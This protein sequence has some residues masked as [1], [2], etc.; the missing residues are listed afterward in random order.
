[1]ATR[2][3]TGRSLPSESAAIAAKLFRGFGDP[4][5]LAILRVLAEG[6]RRVVDIVAAVG[7]SQPN[8][9]GH[10][11]CL[12]E[13]GL[14]ADRPVGRQVF[15]TIAVPEVFDL[16]REAEQLLARVGHAVELCPRY[17]VKR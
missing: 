12:K 7:T 8:V 15:Y 9:S 10:L 1:M 3:G 17:G 2:S 5:R 14:V 4:T 13:C 6:E 16:L 11:A